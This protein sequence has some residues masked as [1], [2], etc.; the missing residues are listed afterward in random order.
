MLY[1]DYGYP[2]LDI[3]VIDVPEVASS[4]T[5]SKKKLELDNKQMSIYK[6]SESFSRSKKQS[7]KELQ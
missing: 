4:I 5:R 3:A 7:Y 2:E 1:K 6:P